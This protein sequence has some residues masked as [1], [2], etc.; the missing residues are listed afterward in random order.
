MNHNDVGDYRK[1]NDLDETAT[2]FGAYPELENISYLK[3]QKRLITDEERERFDLPLVCLSPDLF[4]YVSD[5]YESLYLTYGT[6]R[7]LLKMLSK[8][9]LNVPYVRGFLLA[10]TNFQAKK[11]LVV[12]KL[13]SHTA[14]AREEPLPKIKDVYICPVWMGPRLGDLR[15]CCGDESSQVQMTSEGENRYYVVFSPK[16]VDEI[17]VQ[18]AITKVFYSQLMVHVE[19]SQDI[20]GFKD[21]ALYATDRGLVAAYMYYKHAKELDQ[22]GDVRGPVC[23][24]ADGPGL[25]LDK[26]GESTVSGDLYPPEYSPV[27]KET[28]SDTIR[29]G[30]AVKCNTIVL[31]YCMV[32]MSEQDWNMVLG[33]QWTIHVLD[34]TPCLRPGFV[35]VTPTYFARTLTYTLS[36]FPY[37]IDRLYYTGNLLNLVDPVWVSDGP[38]LDYWQHMHPSQIPRV[39]RGDYVMKSTLLQ[40]GK[41]TVMG[42]GILVLQT[43]ADLLKYRNGYFCLSGKVEDLAASTPLWSAPRVLVPRKI[44]YFYKPYTSWQN[45]IVSSSNVYEDGPV[46]YVCHFGE[47]DQKMFSM[48]DVEDLGE[49]SVLLD[50]RYLVVRSGKECLAFNINKVD[51]Q[52]VSN[53]IVKLWKR[54]QTYVIEK[55]MS[56]PSFRLAAYRSR[57]SLVSPIGVDP[58]LTVSNDCVEEFVM[59]DLFGT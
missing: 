8:S 42:D 48:L 51:Y 38:Y 35:R 47:F 26:W 4:Q 5:N 29:R 1:C 24:P 53:Q 12:Q 33:G 14:V 3:S 10:L 36:H 9:V 49:P 17:V 11:S 57:R 46:V 16:S 34:T 52:D 18:E 6:H 40:R 21:E 45:L 2:S 59:P 32:F 25:C 39:G 58:S 43:W 23:A 56:F 44:Y 22:I 15:W 55:L 28:V 50:G 54:H 7:V 41:M 31:S 13:F 27:K 20:D 30:L 19:K 37:K